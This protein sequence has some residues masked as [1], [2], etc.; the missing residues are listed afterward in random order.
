MKRDKIPLTKDNHVFRGSGGKGW[1][2]TFAEYRARSR[3]SKLMIPE[4]CS[5]L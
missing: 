1:M 2:E 4:E 3:T 5:S